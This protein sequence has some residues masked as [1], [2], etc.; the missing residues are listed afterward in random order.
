MDDVLQISTDRSGDVTYVR[1]KGELDSL[2]VGELRQSFATLLDEG[3]GLFVLDLSDLQFIDSAGLGG[4]V[5]IWEDCV[6]A[7]CFMALGPPSSRVQD[8]LQITGLNSV[9]Q[10]YPSLEEAEGAIIQMR[11]SFPARQG[12]TAGG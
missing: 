3:C 7:G 10:S 11:D 12:T 1:L 8:V 5:S 9:L 2:N 6:Q 4:L